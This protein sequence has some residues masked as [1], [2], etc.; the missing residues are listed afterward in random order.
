MASK[1]GFAGMLIVAIILILF[2]LHL[3]AVI[4]ETPQEIRE[5]IREGIPRVEISSASTWIVAVREKD[6]AGVIGEVL[7]E[8]KKGEGRILM[9]TSPFTEPETQASAKIATE[10]VK[11]IT[12]ANVSQ[13]DIVI[14]F[15]INGTLIGGPSAGASI[16]VATYAAL[17]GKA[18]KE[19][20]V[21]TGT[22]EKSGKIGQ[23]SG[24]YE[25]ANASCEK[26]I[27]LFLI[28]KGAKVYKTEIIEREI[29]G[30]KFVFPHSIEVDLQ[31]EM[32][33]KGMD[34][35]EVSTIEDVIN[36]MIK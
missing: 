26:G 17:E 35:K 8:V 5:T 22:I 21:V 3:N 10:V 23:V 25:K 29:F 32:K 15:K 19:N 9:E 24:I 34:V 28:P 18:I 4:V 33:A 1:K 13:K 27:K 6:Q 20:V 12:G 7:V 30:R 31:K 16:A 14:S 11:K 2:I 36:E